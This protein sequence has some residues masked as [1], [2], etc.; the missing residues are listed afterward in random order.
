MGQG[1]TAEAEAAPAVAV[2]AAATDGV[3]PENAHATSVGAVSIAP[4][5]SVWHA[6][7]YAGDESRI[8]A[9]LDAEG[10]SGLT[11]SVWTPGEVRRMESGG[12]AEPVGRGSPDPSG[13]GDL[14]W[15]GN[16]NQA[17]TYYVRVDNTAA[18][19]ITYVLNIEGAGAW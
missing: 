1:V 16:F 2:A 19:A 18:T 5:A 10:Q 8:L 6:F 15:A 4:G 9:W 12:S 14:L 13:H 7:Q 17:G 3:N 11:V